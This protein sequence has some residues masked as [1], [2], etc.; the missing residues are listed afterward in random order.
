MGVNKV[1]SSVCGQ[2]GMF[3][4]ETFNILEVKLRRV[5]VIKPTADI[6]T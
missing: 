1:K 3:I 5:T 6:R 2:N 4:N